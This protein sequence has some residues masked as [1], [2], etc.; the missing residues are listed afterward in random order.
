MVQKYR[1]VKLAA[2]L[3]DFPS[4]SVHPSII[5]SFPMAHY[6]SAPSSRELCV[7][8]TKMSI[9]KTG[10]C[11]GLVRLEDNSVYSIASHRARRSKQVAGKHDSL[12]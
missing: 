7:F 4:L 6:L 2:R 10:S 8:Q 3:R 9:G 5:G 1:K 11:L 12:M